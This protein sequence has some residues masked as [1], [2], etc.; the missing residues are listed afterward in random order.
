MTSM[1][2]SRY[3]RMRVMTIEDELRAERDRLFPIRRHQ[4]AS[5]SDEILILASWVDWKLKG[6][7][8]RPDP[9]KETARRIAR[10][11]IAACISRLEAREAAK[12][13][14]LPSGF[15]DGIEPPRSARSKSL[16]DGIDDR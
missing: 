5:F 3:G 13:T 14:H 10:Q 9:L 15:A 8:D 4:S 2:G 6:C 16:L 1:P 7:P 12:L 11:N